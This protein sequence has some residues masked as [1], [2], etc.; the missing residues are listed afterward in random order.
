[1]P[2][3]LKTKKNRNGKTFLK[4]RCMILGIRTRILYNFLVIIQKLFMI[5]LS[6]YKDRTE[7]SSMDSMKSY[8][9]LVWNQKNFNPRLLSV[10]IGDFA[11]NFCKKCGEMFSSAHCVAGIPFRCVAGIPFRC[12]AGIPFRCVAGI[13]FRCVAGIPFRWCPTA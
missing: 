11:V 5:F 3:R 7:K 4:K 6:S 1:M 8:M 13:P 12:V 10:T 2:Y 9:I